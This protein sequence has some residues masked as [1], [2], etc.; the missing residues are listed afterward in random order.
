MRVGRAEEDLK[1]EQRVADA[2][3]C[4]FHAVKRV[5]EAEGS[6]VDQYGQNALGA[7]REGGSGFCEGLLEPLG[8]AGA[9]GFDVLPSGAPGGAFHRVA[10]STRSGLGHVRNS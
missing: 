7:P 3:A 8:I 5:R 6:H 4:S 10:R 2:E 9:D 1:R